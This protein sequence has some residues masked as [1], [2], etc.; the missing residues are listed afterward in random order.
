M[1]EIVR[2]DRREA[3]GG[4]EDSSRGEARQVA[5]EGRGRGAG[6]F[7]SNRIVEIRPFPLPP[8]VFRPVYTSLKR[9]TGRRD[10]LD[11]MTV[12]K[13]RDMKVERAG[14]TDRIKF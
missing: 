13:K 8:F 3:G 4:G 6:L 9:D 2:D 10:K 11:L 7:D 1:I 5:R 12:A 14:R